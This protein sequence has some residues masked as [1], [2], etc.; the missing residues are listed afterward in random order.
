M[1]TDYLIVGAGAMGMAFA[2]TILNETPD[3]TLAIVD[4]QGR[5]GGHWN[6]AY[7]FVRLHQPSAFYGVNSRPLGNDV[8]D[9][10]GWN[11]GLYELASGAE[12]L[13]YYDHLMHRDFLPSGR[14]T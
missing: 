8:K 11:A 10:V 3:A 6:D 5:P 2:D 4:R 12:V 7:P 9:A 1:D 14:V 13:A